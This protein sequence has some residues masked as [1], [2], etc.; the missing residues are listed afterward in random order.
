MTRAS[1]LYLTSLQGFR[2]AEL[3]SAEQRGGVEKSQRQDSSKNPKIQHRKKERDLLV[4]VLK[5]RANSHIVDSASL[6]DQYVRNGGKKVGL[7]GKVG[8]G[9]LFGGELV[10]EVLQRVTKEGSRG[11]WRNSTCA[12]EWRLR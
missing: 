1:R 4:R 5:L 11:P 9:G 2:G 8:G 12:N 3:Q 10:G 7:D 6:R